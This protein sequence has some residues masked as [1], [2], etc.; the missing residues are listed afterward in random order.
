MTNIHWT[1]IKDDYGTKYWVLFRHGDFA[2]PIMLIDHYQM[3]KIAQEVLQSVRI[4]DMPEA[5]KQFR[6]NHRFTQEQMAQELGI[7]RNYLSQIERGLAD[8]LTM[9]LYDRIT[10]YLTEND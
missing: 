10:A 7:S 3:K 2:H 5:I 1:P 9:K 6:V 8:N 4:D